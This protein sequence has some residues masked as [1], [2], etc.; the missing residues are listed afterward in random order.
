MSHD[1]QSLKRQS[2]LL[3]V[4]PDNLLFEKLN[5]D[6]ASSRA[7]IKL[8]NGGLFFEK[9]GFIEPKAL[10][11]V[12]IDHKNIR[13]ILSTK[14]DKIMSEENINKIFIGKEISEYDEICL[15]TGYTSN[16]L[17]QLPGLSSKR[18]QISYVKSSQDIENL[19]FPIC[20]SGYFS[21][22][23]GS[24]HVVGSSY[25]DVKI[26]S[27]LEEEHL[28]N[29]KKLEAIHDFEVSIVDGKVGFRAVTKDRMPLVGQKKGV[30]INTGHGSRGSTSAPLCAEII[31]DFID[32]KPLP[33]EN[34]VK[35]ALEVDRFN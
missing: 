29:R 30:Y 2:S 23:R 27:I 11:K 20:A 32:N 16:E 7:G 26:D 24:S 15:C 22:K 3:N 25:S 4:R 8:N 6:E 1:D 9:G 34:S 17:I 10:C 28:I 21:P 5:V 13:E 12:L 19:Q 18:G 14:V 33:V 35:V 31:T